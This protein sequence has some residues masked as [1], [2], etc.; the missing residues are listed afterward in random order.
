MKHC[1]TMHWFAP[2]KYNSLIILSTFRRIY[3]PETLTPTLFFCANSVLYNHYHIVMK[4]TVI[5]IV[6][7]YFIPFGSEAPKTECFKCL[8][9]IRIQLI[10]DIVALL[11]TVPFTHYI[12]YMCKTIVHNQS[13]KKQRVGKTQF[14]KQLGFI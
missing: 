5:V 1:G 7:R 4:S 12:C 3:V 13:K 11:S 9:P 6:S 8:T 10:P 14:G 2:R